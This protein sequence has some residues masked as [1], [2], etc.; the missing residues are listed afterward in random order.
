[1]RE[2]FLGTEGGPVQLRYE[3]EEED[4]Q[5]GEDVGKKK[6]GTNRKGNKGYVSLGGAREEFWKVMFV[7]YF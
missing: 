6:K 5:G 7:G 3:K 4:G 1:M 2:K